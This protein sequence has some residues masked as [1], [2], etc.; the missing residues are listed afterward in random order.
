MY[1]LCVVQAH[2]NPKLYNISFKTIASRP[3]FK[4]CNKCLCKVGLSKSHKGTVSY[5]IKEYLM[6][7][8]FSDYSSI[9]RKLHLLKIYF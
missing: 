1:N 4:A 8:I 3:D 9:N 7:T 2:L 6:K 5:V